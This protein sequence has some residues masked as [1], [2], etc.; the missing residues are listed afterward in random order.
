M[1]IENT[2][3]FLSIGI[4][5]ALSLIVVNKVALRSIEVIRIPVRMDE[6]TAPRRIDIR[7]S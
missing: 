3:L 2:L 7:R 4:V 1:M 6:D 5:G